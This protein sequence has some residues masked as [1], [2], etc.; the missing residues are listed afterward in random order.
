MIFIKRKF[1][2]GGSKITYGY[3]T[4]TKT[5]MTSNSKLMIKKQKIQKDKRLVP[6]LI[7]RKCRL[8]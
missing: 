6:K 2:S 5:I 8:R 1:S 3:M 4:F 7:S